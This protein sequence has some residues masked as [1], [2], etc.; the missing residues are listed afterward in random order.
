MLFFNI[1]F[2]KTDWTRLIRGRIVRLGASG[3]RRRIGWDDGGI[4]T[5]KIV[6][7]VPEDTEQQPDGYKQSQNN[8]KKT[9]LRTHGGT[10]YNYY[11]YYNSI[12]NN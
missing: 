6:I 8:E 11:S 10:P 12:L 5:R 1:S 3:F 2:G 4:R 7:G 9:K